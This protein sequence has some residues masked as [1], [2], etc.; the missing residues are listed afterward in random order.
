MASTY[1]S[2][3]RLELM[4]QG[5]KDNTW[6]DITNTNLQLL[7]AMAHGFEEI[8]LLA[9]NVTLSSANGGT[10]Q[11]RKKILRFTGAT[12]SRT[13]TVPAVSHVYLIWNAG[14]F[15]IV[16]KTPAGSGQTVAANGRSILFC[17]GTNVNALSGIATT[18]FS[19]SL[20]DDPDSLTARGTMG[21]PGLA[22]DSS[23]NIFTASEP[24]QFRWNDSTSSTGPAVVIARDSAS[25]AAGDNCGVVK[26]RARNSIAAMTLMAE[27]AMRMD[28]PLAGSEDAVLRL[29]SI[30]AGTLDDRLFIGNGIYTKSVQDMGADSANALSYW[31]GGVR[32]YPK[33]GYA[34]LEHQL[35]SGSNG[36]TATTGSW[37]TRPLNTEVID[38]GNNVVLAANQFTLEPGTYFIRANAF[39]YRTNHSRLRI[40]NITDS[41]TAIQGINGFANGGGTDPDGANSDC[42]GIVTIAVD[43]AFELQYRCTR[44][45]TS[46]GLGQASS[47]GVNEIFAQVEINKIG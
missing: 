14:S 18:P 25:P 33:I 5:E 13:V 15:D 20:L 26:W 12:A 32:S 2:L 36:G 40:Q 10:D 19:L 31:V 39:F 35:A 22:D 16:V 44:G 6:G 42:F 29:R 38:V 11:A 43:T 37:L 47:M 45:Q 24:V 46:D 28:D 4:T 27:I 1:S 21:V 9:G 41:V 8:S 17:D 30:I 23:R 34:I 3:G 7:E